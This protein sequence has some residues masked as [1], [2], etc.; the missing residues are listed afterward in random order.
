[1]WLT[2]KIYWLFVTLK[3]AGVSAQ[4]DVPTNYASVKLAIDAIKAA[5][6][7]NEATINVAEGE[8]LEDMYNSQANKPMKIT[9]KGAGAGKTLLKGYEDIF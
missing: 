5:V 1:M 9:I 8:Y 2:I 7:V 4:Y 3:N 6:G